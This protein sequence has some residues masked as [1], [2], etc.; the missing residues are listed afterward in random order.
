MNISNK[1]FINLSL[2]CF[3]YLYCELR[4]RLVYLNGIDIS[5]EL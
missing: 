1:L 2:M 3:M 5:I 4:F